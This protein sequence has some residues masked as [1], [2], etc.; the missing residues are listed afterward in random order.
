MAAD[1]FDPLFVQ[2]AA[3]DATLACRRAVLGAT[4][5]RFAVLC[6]V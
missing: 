6:V 4:S 2:R 3:F 1:R 5:G